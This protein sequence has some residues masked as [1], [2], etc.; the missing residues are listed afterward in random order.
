MIT[1]GIAFWP[2]PDPRSPAVPRLWIGLVALG[3]A[4]IRVACSAAEPERMRLTAFFK[5]LDARGIERV[6]GPF[7]EGEKSSLESRKTPLFLAVQ[8]STWPEGLVPVFEVEKAGQIMLRRHPLRGQENVGDP[9]FFGLP[10]ESEPEV[11]RISGSWECTATNAFR[12][13]SHFGWELAMDGERL[14]G[15]FQQG[16]DFR[17]AF[18]IGATFQSNRLDMTVEYIA[19]RYRVWGTW[20]EGRLLGRWK[21]SENNDEGTWE[22]SRPQPRPILPDKRRTALLHEWRKNSGQEFL[23]QYRTDGGESLAPGWSRH[24]PALCRVWLP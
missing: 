18:I 9:L 6:E 17:F 21:H 15:R 5:S 14:S 23:R 4:L 1:S 10:L 12:S 13:K 19:D 7:G 20:N 16:T 24:E 2:R 22:A 3:I 8:S 11:S